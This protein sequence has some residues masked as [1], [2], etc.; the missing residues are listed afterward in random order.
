L[1][2]NLRKPTKVDYVPKWEYLVSGG[3][4]L[5]IFAD[6]SVRAIHE[7]KKEKGAE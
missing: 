7:L 2:G 3:C 5:T 1:D 4:C 6:E